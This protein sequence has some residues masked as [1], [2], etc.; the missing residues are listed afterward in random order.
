MSVGQVQLAMEENEKRKH[1]DARAVQWLIHNKI[2]DQEMEFYVFGFVTTIPG[3]FRSK[4]GIE[5][6][7]K[8][9]EAM[10]RNSEI[11]DLCNHIR[12]LLDTCETP[13]SFQLGKCGA[14]VHV[15][16]L[17]R[18][19]HLYSVSD[20]KLE[21]FG[22]LGRLLL[23]LGDAENIRDLSAAGTDGSFVTHWTCLSLVTVTRWSLNNDLIER[24]AR[25][26]IDT[27]QCS[28]RRRRRTNQ[29]W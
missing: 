10:E 27:L 22:E 29:H 16:V 13:V 1:R 11:Y 18:W 2:G 5:V 3:T 4:W 17:K 9:S 23:T 24:Y 19:P 7:R 14:R 15:D 25:H 6:W 21:K 20:V 12:R 26:A 28:F 8:V